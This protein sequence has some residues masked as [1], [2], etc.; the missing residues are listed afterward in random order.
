MSIK[1]GL[2]ALVVGAALVCG[3]GQAEA[4][5][6]TLLSGS[7]SGQFS[8]GGSSFEELD[9]SFLVV[10]DLST[11]ISAGIFA[12]ITA[13]L[14]P[15]F[16]DERYYMTSFYAQVTAQAQNSSQYYD[17]A[18]VGFYTDACSSIHVRPCPYTVDYS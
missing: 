3:A 14:Q 15:P 6:Y 13:S 8:R 5:T 18:N 10:G 2:R 4:A 17:Y 11:P 12:W 1:T 16:D 9:Q 7:L